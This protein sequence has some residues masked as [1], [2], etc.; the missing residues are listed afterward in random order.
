MVSLLI[1]MFPSDNSRTCPSGVSCLETYSQHQVL[2]DLQH[3]NRCVASEVS[4]E[5]SKLD[6]RY[7]LMSKLN[8]H[9]P[10]VTSQLSEIIYSTMTKSPKESKTS[11]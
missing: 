5:T 2:L 6:H 1:I 4:R 11:S 8:I 7:F 10:T 9:F 3:S